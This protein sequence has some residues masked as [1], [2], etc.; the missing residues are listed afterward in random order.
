MSIWLTSIALNS[1]NEDVRRDLADVVGLHRRVMS[2]LPDGLGEHARQEAGVLYRLESSR[3]GA[4]LLV[5]TVIEP[6]VAR[7]P[8]GYGATSVGKLD[9]FLDRLSAGQ[10]VRYRLAANTSLRRPRGWT[11]PGRPGQVVPL[12]GA[13]AEQWWH[14]RAERVGL[15]LRTAL[16]RPLPDARGRRD[17][18]PV[19]HA[20]TQFDGVAVIRD[21]SALVA[22]VR[23]G[24]GRGKSH[25]CG[26]LS[27]L[28]ASTG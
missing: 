6:E 28:P 11:G 22:A 5:Q 17:G 12:R 4:R 27:L 23:S 19:R 1:R 24:I 2:L 15:V 21:S 7:L 9:L 18:A 10:V 14:K 20:I 25:G 26:L 13:T 16:A 3:D 8:G